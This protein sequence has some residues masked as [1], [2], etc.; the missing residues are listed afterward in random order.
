MMSKAG[1]S[2]MRPQH[3]VFKKEDTIV[4][5]VSVANGLVKA[6]T[7]LSMFYRYLVLIWEALHGLRK[8]SDPVRL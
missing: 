7:P 2:S 6:V 1:I 8:I 3:L 4:V 5:G